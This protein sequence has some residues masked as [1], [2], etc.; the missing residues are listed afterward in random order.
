MLVELSHDEI[1]RIRQWYNA[2]DDCA[3]EYL[4]QADLDIVVRLVRL[5]GANWPGAVRKRK[6]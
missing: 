1:N 3:P 6:E 5:A 4:E 2:A